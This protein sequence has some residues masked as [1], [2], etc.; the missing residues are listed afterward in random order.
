MK[1][2]WI[3]IA[4]ALLLNPAAET[5]WGES[6][7]TAYTLEDCLR[8]AEERN[9]ALQSA[10]REIE[11]ARGKIY[12]SLGD[13][14]PLLQA[15]A[16]YTYL[17]EVASFEVGGQVIPSGLQNNYYLDLKLE[18]TL[19]KGGQVLAGIKAARLY[20]RL[21]RQIVE[22]TRREVRFRVINLFYQGLL[23]EE[24][25]RVRQDT[26][27]NLTRSLDI[28]S[29]KFEQGTASEFD[30]LT[31][32]VKL[33]NAQPL[34]VEALN[35]A[36]TIGSSL[37]RELELDGDS[38]SLEGRL[39]YI[40]F[41]DDLNRLLA[42]GRENRPK[43]EQARLTSEIYAQNVTASSSGYHPE[44]SVY[45]LYSGQR[46]RQGLPPED[47]F[48]FEWQAGAQVRWNLFDGLQT[49][50]R[51]VEARARYEQAKIE[52]DSVVR[53][54]EMEIEQSWLDVNSARTILKSQEET[55]SQ[56]EKAFEIA[57]IR[58]EN[59]LSTYLE[60]TDAELALAAAK[61]NLQQALARYSI[62]LAR[63]EKAVGDVLREEG[64]MLV[65]ENSNQ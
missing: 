2:I 34:L 15:N 56:A 1:K 8:I 64:E 4:A 38:F 46:P 37:A 36:Q 58:W 48:E 19:Y 18:Q 27:A 63:L 25:V 6:P 50:G 59:G 45:A 32:R 44:V 41:D 23:A 20:N 14:L 16:R 35:Q 40:P 12:Q 52:Y 26:V 43:I 10:E 5:A 28:A 62:A 55:V 21:A 33:A 29:P 3:P 17:D 24:V 31:A 65:W 53:Q 54:V 9:L 61:V 13:A 51:R 7:T 11:I 47:R 49:P 57:M 60:L 30:L 42:R 39:Q 22:E